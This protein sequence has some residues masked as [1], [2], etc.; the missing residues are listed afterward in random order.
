MRHIIRSLFSTS[1]VSRRRWLVLAGVTVGALVA[2][3]PAFGQC[4]C[5]IAYVTN[6]YSNTISVVD[7][8][9]NTVIATLGTTNV[10]NQPSDI[11]ITPDGTRA[12]FTRLGSN[13]LSVINTDPS[14][15]L[16]DTVTPINTQTGGTAPLGIAI[17][18]DDGTRAYVANE[19]TNDVSVIDT[20]PSSPTYNR[21]IAIIP[22]GTDPVEVAVSRNGE[23][24]Y[25]T[26]QGSNSVSVINTDTN[27]VVDTIP[28][29]SSKPGG[30]AFA[31]YGHFAY[32]ANQNE[33]TVSVI[34]TITNKVIDTIKVGTTPLLIA[35][36]PH[37][38]L[39]YVTNSGSNSVSVIDTDTDKVV[40]TIPVGTY[41]AGVAVTRDGNRVYVVNFNFGDAGSVSVIDTK[42]T[43]PTFNT[44]LK[45]IEVQSGPREIVITPFGVEYC[46]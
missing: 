11:A 37:R 7:T 45:T 10:E 42:P 39:A 36:S 46:R 34:D 27:K 29:G 43:S 24:V 44:V 2:A 33:N 21:L 20:N 23:K 32:M 1:P 17:T 12:Y 28:L 14:S 18:P 19:S 41:P 40:Q 4:S 15:S 25:V 5:P 26:N 3:A 35:F 8:G 13:I 16:F 31:P 30:V 22:V 38:H 6:Q 9:V